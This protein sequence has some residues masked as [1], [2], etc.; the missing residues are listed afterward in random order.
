MPDLA[1]TLD[2]IAAVHSEFDHLHPHCLRSTCAT[3]FRAAGLCSGLD[4]ERVDKDMMYFF[5]WRSANSV[6]PYID[7]AIRRESCEISL[8]YQASL[9][10]RSIVGSDV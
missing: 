6:R 3:N 4:E 1:L 2:Q 7:A 8:S 9:F 5:G 10:G